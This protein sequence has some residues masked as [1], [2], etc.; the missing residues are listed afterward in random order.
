[1]HSADQDNSELIPHVEAPINVFRNQIIF[2]E[3]D[4]PRCLEEPHQGYRRFY[5][6]LPEHD[7]DAL[8]AILKE[9][10]NPN[11][12]NGIKIPERFLGLLQDVYV[13]NFQRY[14]VRITQRIVEDVMAADRVFEIIENEHKRAHRNPCEN[15]LQILEEYYFPA[16]ARQIR[17]YVRQC[18]TCKLNKYDRHPAKPFLQPTPIPGYPCEILHIDLFEIEKQKYLSAIDKFTK[19]AKLFPI[20]NKSSVH[21]RKKLTDLLHYFSVPKILV[22]DNERDF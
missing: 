17:D 7:A 8:T 1:M 21:L 15:R 18:D 5:V 13:N 6:S 10:L 11:V 12:I 2:R 19:F 3:G 16:M 20:K 9:V 22:M 4:R 14:R